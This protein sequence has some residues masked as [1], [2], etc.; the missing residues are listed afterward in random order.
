MDKDEPKQLSEAEREKIK[1]TANFMNGIAIAFV[2]VTGFSAS[3][4]IGLKDE[5][6]WPWQWNI[7]VFWTLIAGLVFGI[8][9]HMY[10]RAVLD[11]L[12]TDKG[13]LRA[14]Q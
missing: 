3:L 1:L 8:I 14:D 5:S 13:Y 10:A 7:V 9:M 4:Q 2:A 11:H 6:F 12:D